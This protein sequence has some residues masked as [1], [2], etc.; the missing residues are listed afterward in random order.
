M[1]VR[2]K[3]V[4]EAITKMLRNDFDSWHGTQR[5][6]YKW[7]PVLKFAWLCFKLPKT[8]VDQQGIFQNSKSE[9]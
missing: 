2:K 7:I 3:N 9:N 1:H 6:K 4:L 8:W 5:V